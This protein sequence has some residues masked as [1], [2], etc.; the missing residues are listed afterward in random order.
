MIFSHD[1]DCFMKRVFLRAEWRKLA[2]FN[3]VVDPEILR[4][5]LPAN[6]ELDFF[7]GNCFVS[8][9]GFM[10]LQTQLKGIPVPFHQNFEEFNLRFYVRHLDNGTWKRGAVFIKEIVPKPMITMVARTVYKEP[11]ETRKMAHLWEEHPDHLSISYSWKTRQ[12]NSASVKT[13]KIL[14]EI[15]TGSEAEFITEHYWGYTRISDKIT[16]EY[17]VEH[18]RWKMYE[19]LQHDVQIDFLENYGSDFAGIQHKTPSSVFLLEGSG[20][21]VRDGRTIRS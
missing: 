10:F 1:N 18:S 13:G 4:S 9:V 16:S 17:G 6:T 5:H 21:L 7:K 2:M 11:Y 19:T 15:E 14:S 20:I 12:W 3:Y 8:L